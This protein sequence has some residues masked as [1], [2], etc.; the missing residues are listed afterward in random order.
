[1]QIKLVDIEQFRLL[2]EGDILEKFPVKGIP[3]T[4]FDNSKETEIDKYE[5]RTINHKKHCLSLIQ[6]NKPQEMFAWP[7]DEERVYINYHD[8]L[9][10]NTWWISNCPEKEAE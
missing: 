4:I 1:M 10:E 5:I 7:N 6:V 2:K 9:S 8:F 3:V